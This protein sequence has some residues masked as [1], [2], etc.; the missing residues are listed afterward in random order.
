MARPILSPKIEMTALMLAIRLGHNRIAK[1]LLER[2]ANA[3]WRRPKDRATALHVCA[4]FANVE[5]IHAIATSRG[6][7]EAAN[8]S[9]DTPVIVAVRRGHAEMVR[10]LA[11]LGACVKTATKT[12]ATPVF[13]A[14]HQGHVEIVR[15]LAELGACVKTAANRGHT[16][17]FIAAHNGHVETVRV[18]AELG[19]CVKTPDKDGR[20][21]LFAAAHN[22]H[23]KV[24]RL[25]VQ[26]LKADLTTPGGFRPLATSAEGA[27]F[28]ATKTLLL[29]GGPVAVRDLKQRS[30]VTGDTRQLRA[31]LQAWAAD[32]LVQHRIFLSTFLFGCTVHGQETTVEE[33][34]STIPIPPSAHGLLQA[35]HGLPPTVVGETAPMRYIDGNRVVITTETTLTSTAITTV[36]TTARTTN[37]ILPMLEGLPNILESIAGYAG[38]M[39]GHEL[40]RTWE[41]GPAIAEI[42]WAAF[43]EDLD[44]GH[45]EEETDEDEFWN[46]LNE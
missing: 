42:D 43:D 22:G 9:G 37:P 39:T 28:E 31:D 13:I 20:T 44:G 3:R 6:K 14:A 1:L 7:V 19:A 33:T 8:I 11:E 29:L 40:R 38:V 10:V 26:E 4:E 46:N 35:E 21:P 36:A 45:D 27:H 34:T 23:A 18:L 15:V 32:A 17:V 30:H 12:G 16:P 2:G 24:I 25:L 5:M 41:M